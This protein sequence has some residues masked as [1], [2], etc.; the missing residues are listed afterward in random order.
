MYMERE[1]GKTMPREKGMQVSRGLR[2]DSLRDRKLYKGQ[3]TETGR[4]GAIRKGEDREISKSHC[5]AHGT[6]HGSDVEVDEVEE[7]QTFLANITK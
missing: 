2:I 1:R 3:R 6:G 7:D 5:R 4:G